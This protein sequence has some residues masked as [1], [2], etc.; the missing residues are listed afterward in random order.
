MNEKTNRNLIVAVVIL[1]VMLAV[2]VGLNIGFGRG[3]SDNQRIKEQYRELEKTVG[4]LARERDIEREAAREL[5]NLNSEAK[6]IIV[7][8]IKTVE[9]T[10]TSLSTANKI[11]RQVIA[12]LQNLEL[13]YGGD[14]GGGNNGVDS[15]GG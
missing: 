14:R 13:L 9:T 2:S 1:S 8:I 3:I 5:R 7:G 15:L 6:G 4:E 11:L 10:G 12:A